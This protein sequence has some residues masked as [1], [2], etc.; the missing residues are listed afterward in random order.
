MLKSTKLTPLIGSEVDIDTEGLLSGEHADDLRQL[1]IE[2]E[3]ET[4]KCM[5][6]TP[7]VLF[8]VRCGT[9]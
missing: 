8:R 4:R 1:L 7:L 6:K 3:Q 9:L 2:R 5:K